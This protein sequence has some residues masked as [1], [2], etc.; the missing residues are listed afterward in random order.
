MTTLTLR[1]L[2]DDTSIVQLPNDAPWPAWLSA[3]GFVNVTR[4]ADELSIVCPTA[5]VPA[6]VRADDRSSVEDGWTT[7]MIVGPFEFHLTGILLAVLEPLAAASVGIFAI[8]TYDTD[9]VLVKATQLDAAVTAL[10]DA[11]HV[12]EED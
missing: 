3:D 2:G 1:R 6:D 4:T 12:I 7:L 9:Y 8:S 11:G 5:V 10:S